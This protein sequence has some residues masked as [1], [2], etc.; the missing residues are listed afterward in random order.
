MRSASLD[1][2]SELPSILNLF[3][4]DCAAPP[5]AITASDTAYL[6]A[7]YGADLDQNLN[8]EQGDMRERMLHVISNK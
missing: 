8:I 1:T 2:C 5:A 3:A 4:E 7:L 6:K